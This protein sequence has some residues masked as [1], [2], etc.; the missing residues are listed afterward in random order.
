MEPLSLTLLRQ[1]LQVLESFN[2]VFGR[3]TRECSLIRL[4][5]SLKEGLLSLFEWLVDTGMS[6]ARLDRD[7][8]N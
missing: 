2:Q 4:G 3:R 5:K 1:A 8:N 6:R 7:M